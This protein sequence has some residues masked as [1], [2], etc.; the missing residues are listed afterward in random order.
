M[1]LLLILIS[2]FTLVVADT[3]YYNFYSTQK[4][5]TYAEFEVEETVTL[6]SGSPTVCGALAKQG[7]YQAF[8]VLN[9]DCNLGFA[10]AGE[11]NS[12]GVAPDEDFYAYDD[13]SVG[14]IDVINKRKLSDSP[15]V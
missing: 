5:Y 2:I 14:K 8:Q 7:S 12:G 1:T 10:L 4:N 15:A 9:G 6:P 13:K 3:D 11:E